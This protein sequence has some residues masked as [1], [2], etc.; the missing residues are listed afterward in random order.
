MVYDFNVDLHEYLIKHPS[1][2]CIDGVKMVLEAS[3]AEVI[4]YGVKRNNFLQWHWGENRLPSEFFIKYRDL[5]RENGVNISFN[6]PE[7]DTNMLLVDGGT[8]DFTSYHGKIVAKGD[9]HIIISDACV[10][11]F[12]NTRV[13]VTGKAD[14]LMYGNSVLSH[15]GKARYELFDNAKLE[16]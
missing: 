8:H 16:L 6:T 7:E 2:Y 9:A 4:E 15:N 14:C 12:D 5:L 3:P 13:D 10:W 11:A 1:K